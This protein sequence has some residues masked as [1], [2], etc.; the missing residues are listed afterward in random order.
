MRGQSV[1]PVNTGSQTESK[2]TM[3]SKRIGQSRKPEESKETAAQLR[4]ESRRRV[5]A[6]DASCWQGSESTYVAARLAASLGR[7]AA[8]APDLCRLAATADA[9]ARPLTL[10]WRLADQTRPGLRLGISLW[11]GLCAVVSHDFLSLG[12]GGRR[13]CASKRYKADPERTPSRSG[14]R[15]LR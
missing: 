15:P 5:T 1:A 12:Y 14:F 6:P 8:A 4:R 13:R 3:R 10:K 11:L 2:P 9:L 7:D